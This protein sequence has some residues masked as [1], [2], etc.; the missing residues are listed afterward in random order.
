MTLTPHLSFSG[1]CEAAFHF[2]EQCLGGKIVTMLT[3][4]NSPMA[5]EVPPEWH[6]KICHATLTVG[7]NSLAGSDVPP[8]SYERLSGFQVLLGLDD[9]EEAERIFHAL[10][11]NGTVS[12]PIQK[13]FWS[14]RFGTLVDCFGVPWEINCEQAP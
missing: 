2:Y 12:V 4:G 3:W 10:A 13:T 7:A 5:N 14:A 1:Q 8:G 11:N 9:P 6:G